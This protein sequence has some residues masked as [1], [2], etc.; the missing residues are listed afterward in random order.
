ME[1]YSTL[2]LICDAY[3]LP[4]PIQKTRL[5]CYNDHADLV[6]ILITVCFIELQPS[7]GTLFHEKR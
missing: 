6:L 7:Q 1:T 2:I 4:T 5:K 3:N